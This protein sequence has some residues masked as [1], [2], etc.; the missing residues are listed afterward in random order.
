METRFSPTDNCPFCTRINPPDAISCECGATKNL[1]RE[2]LGSVSDKQV[3]KFAKFI[4]PNKKVLLSIG[5]VLLVSYLLD[6][7]LVLVFIATLAVIAAP[8]ILIF[9][10]IQ[11]S[12]PFSRMPGI[13]ELKGNEWQR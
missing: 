11:K 5:G 3:D 1:E 7:W 2:N 6:W 9:W 8:V 12:K 10:I 13:S 4:Y